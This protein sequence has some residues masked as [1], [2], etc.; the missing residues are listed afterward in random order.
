MIIHLDV[1]LNYLA[2]VV[3]YQTSNYYTYLLHR[4]SFVNIECNTI[5]YRRTFIMNKK[6]SFIYT[7]ATVGLILF[8]MVFI[9]VCMFSLYE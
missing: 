1:R 4:E 8:W 6:L 2:G 3:S 9:V 7:V 5:I